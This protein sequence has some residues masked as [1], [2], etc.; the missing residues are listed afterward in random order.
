MFSN[1]KVSGG[2]VLFHVCAGWRIVIRFIKDFYAEYW[3]AD[4]Y[5]NSDLTGIQ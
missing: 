2:I 5:T 1:E 4:F 3:R